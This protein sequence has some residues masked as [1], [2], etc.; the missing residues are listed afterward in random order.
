VLDVYDRIMVRHPDGI[1][2][3]APRAP[4]RSSSGSSPPCKGD[5]LDETTARARAFE[6]VLLELG[7]RLLGPTL[8]TACGLTDGPADDAVD[9]VR[10][11]QRTLS[12]PS[13]RDGS[14]SSLGR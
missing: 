14:D 1:D 3:A 9:L 8:A 4:S 11:L 13:F 2:P 10:R 7:L 12:D 6:V 5:G